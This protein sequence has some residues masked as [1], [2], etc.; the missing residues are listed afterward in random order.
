MMMGVRAGDADCCIDS[1]L[2]IEQGACRD[3][4]LSSS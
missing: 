3:I 2:M 4:A 1:F